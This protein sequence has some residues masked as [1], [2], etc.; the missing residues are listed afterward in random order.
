LEGVNPAALADSLLAGTRLPTDDDLL[1]QF[2]LVVDKLYGRARDARDDTF[3]AWY[4]EGVTPGSPDSVFTIT[5][6]TP[7]DHQ[8]I[9]FGRSVGI[10]RYTYVHHGTVAMADAKLTRFKPGAR[11]VTGRPTGSRTRRRFA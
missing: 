7:P 5:Y 6:R 2:P 1:F 11:W 9:E 8:I 3:Y 10:V 4:V